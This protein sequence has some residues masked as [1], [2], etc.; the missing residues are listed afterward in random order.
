MGTNKGGLTRNHSFWGML[1]LIRDLFLTKIFYPQAR[2]VRRPIYLRGRKWM[3]IGKHFTCGRGLRMDVLPPSISDGCL[4]R[5]GSE[6][7]VNDYVHIAV[8]HSVS[9]GDRVLI[10]SKVFISDH[11]HGTYKGDLPHD[12]P[13]TPPADRK[14]FCSPVIIEDDVWIG[15]FAAILPGVTIGRG[16]I[17]GTHSTVTRNIPAY[18]IAVGSPAKVIK[19]YNFETKTWEYV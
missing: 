3:R 8:A 10:A 5:I 12:S 14:L 17:I 4:L 19:Q 2:L 13:L 15:E 6:V 16:A 9:I 11:G 1:L 18:S 7:Q